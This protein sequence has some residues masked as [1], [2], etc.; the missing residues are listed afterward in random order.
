MINQ[1]INRL[2]KDDNLLITN[3]K[4]NIYDLKP[5]IANISNSKIKKM[6]K[7]ANDQDPILTRPIVISKDNF[8]IDGHHRWYTRKYLVENNTNSYNSDFYNEDIK[9]IIIDYYIKKLIEKLQEYKIHFNREYLSQALLDI[10]TTNTG[11]NFMNQLRNNVN[12]NNVNENNRNEKKPT[13]QI[14]KRKNKKINKRK[15]KD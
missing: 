8:I 9:V 4:V 15:N 12:E 11:Q 13:T 5:T 14:N 1:F 3:T 7:M 6:V 10:K 2:K